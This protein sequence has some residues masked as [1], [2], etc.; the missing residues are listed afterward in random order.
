[1]AFTG[2]VNNVNSYTNLTAILKGLWFYNRLLFYATHNQAAIYKANLDGNAVE[3]IVTTALQ[4]PSG[5]AIDYKHRR[6]C[7]ADSGKYI[8]TLYIFMIYTTGI[9]YQT[10]I[11]YTSG[12]MYKTSMIY[13]SG[14]MYQTVVIYTSSI[15][16][17]NVMIYTSSITY[18]NVMM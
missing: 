14:I 2:V 11:I 15:M 17:Q 7:W 10:V 8:Y 18:Q 3:Q 13:R 6:V 5:M 12:I 16:Y 9:M 1:M 4:T